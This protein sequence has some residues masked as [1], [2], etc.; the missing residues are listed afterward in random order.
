MK[1]VICFF[2]LFFFTS[3]QFFVLNDL[4]AHAGPQE[5]LFYSLHASPPARQTGFADAAK[6]SLPSAEL[7]DTS[8]ASRVAGLQVERAQ[9]Q[10]IFEKLA[11]GRTDSL[12]RLINGVDDINQNIIKASVKQPVVIKIFSDKSLDSN[13]VKT[14]FQ[15]AAGS[16]K[17]KVSFVGLD[18]FAHCNNASEN[19][20]VVMQIMQSQNL[21]SISLPMFLFY[22]DGKLF[23]PMQQGFFTQTNL[24]ELTRNMFFRDKASREAVLS[25]GEVLNDRDS[26]VE[27]K[28]QVNQYGQPECD[29]QMAQGKLLDHNKKGFAAVQDL[30]ATSTSASLSP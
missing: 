17:N 14:P 5:S 3:C 19:Y 11:D 29:R 16:Y 10:A 7:P 22:Q 21:R 4:G 30:T 15:Q 13:K 26:Q 12:V 1:K 24:E 8:A 18:L 28:N 23:L 9:A 6:A 20:S 27:Q 25:V 2:T